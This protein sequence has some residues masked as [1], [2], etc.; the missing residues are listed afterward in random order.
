MSHIALGDGVTPSEDRQFE[1]G[2]AAARDYGADIV[3][4]IGAIRMLYRDVVGASRIGLI[5][6]SSGYGAIRE[7]AIAD[8][9]IDAV[10]NIDGNEKDA[11]HLRRLSQAAHVDPPCARRAAARRAPAEDE[12]AR[13]SPGHPG[14]KTWIGDGL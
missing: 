12:G 14:S 10:V 2:L 13:G 3:F 4:A 8:P 5:G 11:E 1:S 9:A 7:A 6:H